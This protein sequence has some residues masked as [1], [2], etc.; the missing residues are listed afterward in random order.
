MRSPQVL[1][2][3]KN[4]TSTFKKDSIVRYLNSDSSG[5]LYLCSDLVQEQKQEWIMDSD[6]DSVAS[7]LVLRD[8]ELWK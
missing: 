7:K 1:Y 8:Y 4:E 5:H 6:L 2:V 3:V